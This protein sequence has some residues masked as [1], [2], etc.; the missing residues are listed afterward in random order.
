ML[1]KHVHFVFETPKPQTQYG[2]RCYRHLTLYSPLLMNSKT[3]GL[4]PGVFPQQTFFF[5]KKLRLC[6]VP[7]ETQACF[8]LGLTAA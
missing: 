2:E 6:T 5:D 3:Q 7:D 8:F 1:G 4:L